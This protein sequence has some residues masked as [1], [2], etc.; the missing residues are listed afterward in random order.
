MRHVLLL[1][2]V[3]AMTGIASASLLGPNAGFE[4]GH[5]DDWGEWGSGSDSAGWWG[6]GENTVAVEDGTAHTGDWYG[7][8]TADWAAAWWVHGN[9][10]QEIEAGAGPYDQGTAS[11]SSTPARPGGDGRS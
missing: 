11:L 8:I 1:L 4:L 10:Y 2:T 6:W 9:A 5:T 3:L 7:T